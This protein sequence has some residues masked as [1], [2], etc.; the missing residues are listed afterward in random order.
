MIE[1]NGKKLKIAMIAACD[2]NG[3]IGIDGQI[4]W[5]QP[6]DM[7]FFKETTTGH[8]LIMGRATATSLER[9]LPGRR[10]NIAIAGQKPH[11]I[12]EKFLKASSPEEALEF[13]ADHLPVSEE[14]H[15][16]WVIGGAH[17]YR[18]FIPLAD[19]L[20][21]TVV[22]R[23]IT[24]KPHNDLAYFPLRE[25]GIEISSDRS[26]EIRNNSVWEKDP[27]FRILKDTGFGIADVPR[28]TQYWIDRKHK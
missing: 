5:R 15:T 10:C 3:L 20:A 17:V 7:R 22:E 19:R 11:L 13:A 1:I 28:A 6:D 23:H 24:T 21:L 27:T 12:P 26:L 4:P 18:S 2:L 9:P 25:M 8:C 16:V 14:D